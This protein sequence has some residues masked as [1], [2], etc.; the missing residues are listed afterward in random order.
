MSA[1][2][3]APCAGWKIGHNHLLFASRLQVAVS[4]RKAHDRIR[5]AH[6]YPL[7]IRSGR[8]KSNPEWPFKTGGKDF[9]LFRFSVF[10][11]PSKY[12]DLSLAA[13]SQEQVT[14]GRGADQARII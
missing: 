9:G 14:I 5:I 8:I 13:F 6:I 11:Q 4:I 10:G 7:R 2:S 12:L 1:T 3:Q